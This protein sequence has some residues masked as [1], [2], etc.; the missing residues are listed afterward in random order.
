MGFRAEKSV[1]VETSKG[2]EL[3]IVDRTEE[4]TLLKGL[5][6]QTQAG[7]GQ[8]AFIAGEGGIGKTRLVD[9]LGRD[10]RKQGAIFAVG[11]SYED[12]ASIPY[13]PW[14][15]LIRSIVRQMPDRR[16]SRAS[17]RTVAEV[18]RL[19]PEVA[20]GN[21]ELGIKGWLTGS[22][23]TDL[24]GGTDLDRTRLFQAV[25]DFLTQ[26]SIERPIVLF[27]DDI[28]WADAASIQ[29]L[30]YFCRRI[31]EERIMVVAA[32]RDVELPKKHPLSS[33]LLD[34]N[35]ER[36]LRQ[37]AL[38]RLTTD[39]VAEIISNHLGGGGVAPEFAKLIHTRTGGNP[40]FVEEVLRLLVDEARVHKGERGWTLKE[41]GQVEIPSTVRAL[42]E[43]RVSRIGEDLVQTLSV[44]S[45]VGMNFTFELLLR[46]TGLEEDALISQI[47][48]MIQAGMVTERRIGRE[49]SYLFPDEQVR[50]YFYKDLSLIRARKIHARIAAAIE[51]H[52]KN[53]LDRHLDE[54]AFHYIQA[55]EQA[56]AA[57]F[58][59]K[60]GDYA[61]RL[62]AY[63]EAK[64]HYRNVLDLIEGQA[65]ERLGVLT[66]L[67]DASYQI[68]ESKEATRY[69]TEAAD[70]AVGLRRSRKVVQIYS[71]LGYVAWALESDKQSALAYFRLGLR[72]LETG[73]ESPEKATLLQNMGRLLVITGEAEEGRPLCEE[74]LHIAQRLNIFSV[75]VEA[76]QT[77]AL[78]LNRDSQHKG[79]ILQY[80][81][82]ALKIALDHDLEEPTSR[83]FH[84]VACQYSFV[85][86]DYARTGETLMRGVEFS[87]KTADLLFEGI[88]EA[89][90]AL[91]V[92]LPLGAWGKAFEA[93]NRSFRVSSEYAIKVSLSKSY[94]ALGVTHLC[95]GDLEKA[96]E[97]LAAALPLVEKIQITEWT[98]LCHWALGRL[99]IEKQDHSRAEKHLLAAAEV[100]QHGAYISTHDSHFELVRLYLQMGDTEKAEASYR[101]LG[102]MAKDL[103][104][105]WAYAYEYWAKG[106]L[107]ASKGNALE[108]SDAFA[109]SS[110]L[111]SQLKHRYH[112]ART[113]YELG[114][115]LS[116]AG[117][118][119]NGAKRLAE[120]K[121]I[122]DELGAKLDLLRI[123]TQS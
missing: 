91:Y 75:Q 71:R 103:D 41:I 9:E 58:S 63:P 4:L 35:R 96:E 30:H 105:P 101:T 86:A 62:H 50:D 48:R 74:A 36:V 51:E 93:A 76:I 39:F 65:G 64:E 81:E 87:K 118:N 17:S 122:F 47:E 43:H 59:L 23:R 16:L 95:R 45:A 24:L 27:L 49:V 55:G 77:L 68:G 5:F 42:I 99:Y 57:E 107:A 56:K 90:Q 80:C 21:R 52:H 66:K 85:K 28:L 33:L 84:N 6:G 25:T 104:E 44:A 83:A 46:V 92:Y 112:Y 60:A 32:Y 113:V 120:A 14:V 19:V 1:L 123:K 53:D 114:K 106:L 26:L 72:A 15:E 18:A 88:M 3:P 89:E 116:T 73:E 70:L 29:L 109:R 31:K 61:F 11:P 7:R 37:I 12:E 8:V 40:F 111:W 98:Y 102:R 2:Q 108:A 69:F 100:G 34:L 79:E 10:A 119:E 117:D 94:M 20:P 82:E 13:S 110:E 54:L 78:G 97:S 22:E 115:T 67:G 121:T 38:N